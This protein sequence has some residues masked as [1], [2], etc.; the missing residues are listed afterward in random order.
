MSPVVLVLLAVGALFGAVVQSATG[1][2]L[3]LVIAPI[4]FAVLP[5]PQA[6]L[7]V[8]C[9]TT[10]LNVAMLL[11]R[12]GPRA[13]RWR[14]L[15]V[16][17]AWSVPGIVAGVAIVRAAPR[18]ALQVAVG[19]AVIGALALRAWHPHVVLAGR[20][21]AVARGVV[22][23]VAGVLTTTLSTTGPPLALWLDA[24]G[25]S[26]AELRDSLAFAFLVL[27]TI[28]VVTLSRQVTL[29]H[30]ALVAGAIALPAVGAGFLV[31]RAL[32][33]RL[34]VGTAARATR[35]VVLTAGL[36]SIVAGIS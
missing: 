22:G 16:V 36:S 15:A 12:R 1:L 23:L 20:R 26:P 18:P 13:V 29:G 2:G 10:T 11:A 9:L 7:L 21:R 14:A 8:I 32:A 33:A 19:V 4:V 31:G 27:N 6:V 17:L 30:D 35:V 28:G 5:P 34:D 3:G 24:E 25:A